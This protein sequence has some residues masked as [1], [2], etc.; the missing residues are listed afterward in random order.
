MLDTII[1]HAI[2]FIGVVVGLSCVFVPFFMDM[3]EHIN[4]KYKDKE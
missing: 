4:N 3:N 1:I 2:I